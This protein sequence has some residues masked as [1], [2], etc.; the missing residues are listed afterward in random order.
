MMIIILRQS[1]IGDDYFHMINVI[2]N[3]DI[4]HIDHIDHNDVQ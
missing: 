1:L 2:N 4:D 3:D